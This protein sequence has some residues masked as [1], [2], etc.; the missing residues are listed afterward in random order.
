V[1]APPAA[2]P[3]A[4]DNQKIMKVAKS[5]PEKD[6]IEFIRTLEENVNFDMSPSGQT[7]LIAA[8]VSLKT[9]Q[10]MKMRM[11]DGPE[12]PVEGG[13]RNPARTTPARTQPAS[14]KSVQTSVPNPPSAA[15]KQ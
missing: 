7:D 5:V 2:D 8:G 11:T 14:P 6:L 1:L 15:A 4:W 13:T 3:N 10:A 12:K 9:I